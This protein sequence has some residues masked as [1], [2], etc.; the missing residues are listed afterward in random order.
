MTEDTRKSQENAFFFFFLADGAGMGRCVAQ[1]IW[2]FP[3]LQ[4]NPSH[5]SDNTESLTIRS[6]ENSQE[7]TLNSNL[8]STLC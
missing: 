6:P 3:G 8:K 5:N 4:L 1:G 2:K 7:N